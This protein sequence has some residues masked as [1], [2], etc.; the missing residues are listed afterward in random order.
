MISFCKF[1]ICHDSG[2]L[3]LGNALHKNVIAIYGP[4]DPDFYALNLPTFH[5][6]RKPCDCTPLLGLFPGMLGEPTEEEVALKCPIP[7]CMERLTVGEV[8]AKCVELL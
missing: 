1:L 5:V 4:S 7:Q 8:Y 6:L 2:L 3:H